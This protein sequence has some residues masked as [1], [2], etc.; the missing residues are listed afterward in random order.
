MS[1]N[2]VSWDSYQ[3]VKNWIGK[4]SSRS[5]TSRDS[6]PKVAVLCFVEQWSPIAMH[7]AQM[8]EKLRK[9]GELTFCQIF[10]LDCELHD[11]AC[12][13]YDVTVTPSVV[14]L[15]EGT[16]FNVQR[17]N[18]DDDNKS[19]ASSTLSTLI[20]R[21]TT[22]LMLYL[23]LNHTFIRTLDSCGADLS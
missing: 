22:N 1:K 7:T 3:A 19:M 2:S 12:L 14:F 20:I 9:G 23:P 16:P 15:W 5:T 11:D 6:S 21:S 4:T 18:W 8:F 13:D 17:P 10:I